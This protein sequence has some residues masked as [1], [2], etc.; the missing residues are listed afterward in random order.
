MAMI[1]IRNTY[2][3]VAQPV[4]TLGLPTLV[5]LI[6]FFTSV[7]AALSTAPST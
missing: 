1:I 6:D 2:L 7:V 4:L 5:L 3:Q